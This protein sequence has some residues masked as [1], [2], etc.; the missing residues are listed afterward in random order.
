LPVI[1]LYLNK[2]DFNFRKIK[3]DIIFTFL[4]PLGLV[5]FVMFLYA[6][7]GDPLIQSKI[8]AAHG[9]EFSMPWETFNSE[10]AGLFQAVELKA[11]AYRMFNIFVSVTFFAMAILS[12]R[13]M[14]KDY[15]I[16]FLIASVLPLFSGNLEAIGRYNLTIFPAFVLLQK[17]FCTDKNFI[18]NIFCYPCASDSETR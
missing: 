4:I 17:I 5:I 2:K 1:Y 8:F 13:F 10:V 6:T 7:T 3:S 14:K 18:Y 12:F 9:K 11:V 15:V 16:Y